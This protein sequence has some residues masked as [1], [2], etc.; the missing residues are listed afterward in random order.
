MNI[1]YGILGIG[2]LA[3]IA[4]LW[5]LYANKKS[6]INEVINNIIRKF[7]E[8]KIEVIEKDKVIVVNKIENNEK[9]SEDTKKEIIQIK[10]KANIEIKEILKK[11]NFEDLINKVDELW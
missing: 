3:G 5:T 10:E 9:L 7:K 2:G 11:D 1:I 8:D 6:D 4:Y